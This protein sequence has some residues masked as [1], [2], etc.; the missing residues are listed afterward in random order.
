MTEDP[1]HAYKTLGITRTTPWDEIRRTHRKLMLANHPDR[2]AGQDPAIIADAEMR[3]RDINE[4][5]A[6]IRRQRSL[7]T[8]RR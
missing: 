8:S 5:Y 1:D 4:A 2:F 3:V 7:S 6:E